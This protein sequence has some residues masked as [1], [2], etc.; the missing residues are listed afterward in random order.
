[1]VPLML[2]SSMRQNCCQL[3]APSI[4][5]A[6]YMFAG[7]ACIQGHQ[8]QEGGE[9][10][11]LGENQ[12]PHRQVRG[13]EPLDPVLGYS[14]P[15]QN[16]VDHPV[17]AVEHDLPHDSV[18]HRRDGPGNQQ[19]NPCNGSSP[20]SSVQQARDPDRQSHSPEYREH[21]EDGGSEQRGLES[22][23]GEQG[24]IVPHPD[25]SVGCRGF[26]VDPVE[27]E[28]HRIQHRVDEQGTDGDD[29]RG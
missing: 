2:G 13:C 6:R 17:R 20:E 4:V 26:V 16:V 29:G 11:D 3:L 23:I 1:M 22:G 24:K 9:L 5:A 19:Q 28:H 25:D 15:H 7:I 10:P 12:H 8:R 14:K 27:R 18:H 21:A